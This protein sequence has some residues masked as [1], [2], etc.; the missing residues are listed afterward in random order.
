MPPS[1]PARGQAATFTPAANSS[2]PPYSSVTATTRAPGPTAARTAAY[3]PARSRSHAAASARAARTAG[4]ARHGPTNGSRLA[5][6]Y[7]ASPPATASAN[8]GS[9]FAP[10]ARTTHAATPPRPSAAGTSS[11]TW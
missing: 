1:S 11:G 7:P 6:A 8:S 10:T 3:R 5:S 4:F 9:R 2:G